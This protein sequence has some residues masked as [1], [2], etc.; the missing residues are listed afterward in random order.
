MLIPGEGH[1]INAC[2]AEEFQPSL[3]LILVFNIPVDY[4]ALP[5]KNVLGIS[6]VLC[7]GGAVAAPGELSSCRPFLPSLSSALLL[8]P[9]PRALEAPSLQEADT[10]TS[11]PP[12]PHSTEGRG[13]SRPTVPTAGHGQAGPATWPARGGVGGQYLGFG[14]LWAVNFC[15]LSAVIQESDQPHACQSSGLCSSPGQDT[16]VSLSWCNQGSPPAATINVG[17]AG[18]NDSMVRSGSASNSP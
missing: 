13:P 3:L 17:L 18:V 6:G 9:A 12:C 16:W 11:Q 4:P 8:L 1:E 14:C 7:L 5:E 2:P 10:G 15:H